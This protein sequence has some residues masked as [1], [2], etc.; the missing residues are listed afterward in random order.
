[1][2][3]HIQGPLSHIALGPLDAPRMVFVHPNPMDSST[4]LY[5]MAHFSTWYRCIA[6]DIPGYGRSAS[7]TAGITMAEI[8][9]AVWATADRAGGD[10]D[11]PAVLVGCS[12]GSHIVEYMYWARPES[13]AAIVLSGTSWLGERRQFAINGAANY[14][15]HGVGYRYPHAFNDFSPEFAKSELVKWY[16]DL[17]AER[18]GT[19]DA[20]TIAEMFES[21][22]EPDPLEFY[23]GLD[24]PVLILTGS[25]DS[26]HQGAFDLEARLPDARLITL[27]GAG[28]ACYY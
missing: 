7:A 16:A 2:T 20:D 8:A 3:G 19:A 17:I 21:R 22:I 26:A 28:H 10:P 11:S 5:Q 27:E 24:A 15:E 6:V 18:A 23:T 25:E 14:R 1:M 4:W 13:T 12:V 9:E